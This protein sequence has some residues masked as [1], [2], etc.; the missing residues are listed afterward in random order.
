MNMRQILAVSVVYCVVL[1]LSGCMSAEEKEAAKNPAEP[2][3]TAYLTSETFVTLGGVSKVRDEL[4]RVII[5]RKRDS[6]R[7]S[8]MVIP[9]RAIPIGSEV[10]VFE[11]QW[12]T[13]K[14]QNLGPTF[15][16]LMIE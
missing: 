8:V 4:G 13:T 14:A 1:F 11:V 6:N 7:F 3:V 16:F 5:M 9:F 12:A 10:K 15:K 2:I